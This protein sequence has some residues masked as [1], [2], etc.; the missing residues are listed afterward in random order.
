MTV[1]PAQNVEVRLADGS[2]RDA[3]FEL[4]HEIYIGELQLRH[5]ASGEDRRMIDEE[6]AD[7]RLLVAVADGQLVGS[8]RLNLGAD[9]PIHASF[10]HDLQLDPFLE[11][12]PERRV[13]ICS[14]FVVSPAYRG[15]LVPFQLFAGAAEEAARAGVELVFCDCQPHLIRL[16]YA[17]GFRSYGRVYSPNGW[18][19]KVPLVLLGGDVEHMRAVSS[20]LLQLDL[21]FPVLS[22]ATRRAAAL[23]PREPVVR[24]AEPLDLGRPAQEGPLHLLRGLEPDEIRSVSEHSY[25]IELE[26]G[27][28]LISKGQVTRTVYLVLEGQLQARDGGRSVRVMHTGD[29]VGELAF[30]LH[31]QRTLDVVVSSERA[32]VL[33]LHEP[34]LRLMLDSDAR[35][36]ARLL[37]NLC[38][39]LAQ[40]LAAPGGS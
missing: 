22:E 9:A 3:V 40:R 21:E 33:G 27:T 36:A 15:T 30:L 19:I 34:T 29:T 32:S 11:A 39:T 17:L 6:D 5:L 14:R 4:R 24:P 20:P 25:V 12:V 26:R 8:M 28:Q 13:M 10:R 23:L 37:W 7:G 1:T 38:E 35:A 18:A 16:Y 31:R 2:E